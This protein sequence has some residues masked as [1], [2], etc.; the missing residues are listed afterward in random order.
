MYIKKAL[1]CYNSCINFSDNRDQGSP[2]PCPASSGLTSNNYVPSTTQSY[3]STNTQT[4]IS[5]P[6]STSA[7][8]FHYESYST[9]DWDLYLRETNSTAAPIECF[10]QV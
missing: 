8:A 7:T 4:V 2:V 1:S 6:S 9:F 5:Q 10:K 3:T